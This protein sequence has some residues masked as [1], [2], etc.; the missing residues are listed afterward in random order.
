MVFEDKLRI[1]G[2]L[3]KMAER[4][5]AEV[6]SGL[7]GAAVPTDPARYAAEYLFLQRLAF[8]GKA[9]SAAGGAW[10]SPGFNRTSAYGTAATARFGAVHPMI[11]SLIR[12][13][14]Q[15]EV[16]LRPV[17]VRACQ[18]LAQPPAA[19]VAT[20]TLVYL[21]PPYKE[22]TRYPDGDMTRDQ[23]VTLA[24]AWREAGATVVVS[25]QHGLDMPAGWV[26][27]RLWCGRQDTSPFRGKQEEWITW[28]APGART[29][30][31]K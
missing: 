18:Q 24:E 27:E 29:Y 8:S 6:Y 19:Q 30:D 20:R 11:P 2:L 1:V 25:E 15:Y 4:D 14:Q 3:K 10:W 17:P 5:P 13:L 9:V 12:T 16:Q 28:A 7:H 22:S 26:R 31:N 21:D 23:V